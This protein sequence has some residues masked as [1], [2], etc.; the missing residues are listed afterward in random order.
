[1]IHTAEYQVDHWRMSLLLETARRH[2]GP[3]ARY[4]VHAWINN[5]MK[6]GPL[7]DTVDEWTEKTREEEE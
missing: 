4:F 3:Y 1:M 2:F 6:N 7:P 5:V